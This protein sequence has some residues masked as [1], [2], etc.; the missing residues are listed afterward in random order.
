MTA[1]LFVLVGH[2]ASHWL[3]Q[4][5]FFPSFYISCCSHGVV[6]VCGGTDAESPTLL[7]CMLISRLNICIFWPR[8]KSGKKIVYFAHKLMI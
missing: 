3:L 2:H 4:C 1:P 5:I 6:S 7:S 8:K